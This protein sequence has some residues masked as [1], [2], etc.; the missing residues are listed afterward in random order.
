MDQVFFEQLKL[1]QPRY[2]LR[3]GSGT[4]AEETGKMMM[5]IEKILLEEKPSIVLV[6]GDTNTV[7]AGAWHRLKL[8]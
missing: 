6:E 2:N 3:V 5:G 8:G 1:P 4:H 7:L